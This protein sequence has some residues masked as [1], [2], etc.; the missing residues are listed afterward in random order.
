MRKAGPQGMPRCRQRCLLITLTAVFITCFLFLSICTGLYLGFNGLKRNFI[1]QSIVLKPDSLSTNFLMTASDTG[2]LVKPKLQAI[3]PYVYRQHFQAF[4]FQWS[5][6]G[7][8]TELTYSVNISYEFER[9]LSAGDP[10]KDILFAPKIPDITV[11]TLFEKF[12]R[13]PKM[14][15]VTRHFLR[16]ILKTTPHK[17]LWGYEDKLLKTCNRLAPELCTMSEIGM[18]HGKK[19]SI[20]GPYKIDTGVRDH[21]K[22]GFLLSVENKSELDVW[23]NPEANKFTGPMYAFTPPHVTVGSH[24]EMFSPLVCRS[25][26][27]KVA[28]TVPHPNFEHLEVLQMSL[29]PETLHSTL[30]H[31]SNRKYLVNNTPGPEVPP[32]G[33]MDLSKC[34]AV[35]GLQVPIFGSL[36]F[37][38]DASLEVSSRVEFIDAPPPAPDI[39]LKVEPQ[40]GLIL[41]GTKRLQFNIYSRGTKNHGVFREFPDDIFLPLAYVSDY[42]IAGKEVVENLHYMLNVLPKILANILLSVAC[43]SLLAILSTLAIFHMLLLQVDYSYAYLFSI[44]L[45]KSDLKKVFVDEDSMSVY[46]QEEKVDF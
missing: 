32:S 28:D 17:L 26:T 9:K 24:R 8:Y 3:G 37:F 40:T 7:Q 30:D 18:L 31:P 45:G 36:P 38:R 35:A 27:F 46:S 19:S 29:L 42:E 39:A 16:P 2:P 44:L 25:F 14:G 43:L 6:D 10:E 23:I 20:H 13:H 12:L 34:M 22:L 1:E 21:A 41:E 5:P 15:K 4:D 11:T 33:V